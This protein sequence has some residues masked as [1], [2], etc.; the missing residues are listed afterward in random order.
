MHSGVR[1]T[2][3]GKCP[4]CGMNLVAADARFKILRHML[5]S[6]LHIVLMAAIMLAVMVGIM[7]SMR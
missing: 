1:A 5:G 2:R 6:P 4:T 3:P 7:M